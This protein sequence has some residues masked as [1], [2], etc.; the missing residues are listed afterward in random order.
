MCESFSFYTCTSVLAGT[1]TRYLSSDKEVVEHKEEE[2]IL[3][4]AG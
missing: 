3:F 1:L 2:A 4:P